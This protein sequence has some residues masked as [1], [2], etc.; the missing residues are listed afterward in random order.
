MKL[1]FLKN[2]V[3]SFLIAL[4]LAPSAFIF[5]VH[6][7][8]AAVNCTGILLGKLTLGLF[9][10]GVNRVL[11]VPTSNVVLEKDTNITAGNST[12]L[13]INECII[14][15]LVRAMVRSALREITRSTVAWINS[16]FQGRPGFVTN[17]EGFLREV[18]DQAAGQVI[19]SIAPQLC[20]PFSLQLRLSLG[21]HYSYSSFD[22]IGCRL[23]DVQKNIYNAFVGGN[24]NKY[25]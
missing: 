20:G 6:K 12:G 23:S 11:S 22:R 13:L 14:K 25:R 2:Y 18:G 16:G 10:S 17:P 3:P 5:F 19:E 7:A 21:L 15:P 8:K 24:F 1:Y 9:G 4:L